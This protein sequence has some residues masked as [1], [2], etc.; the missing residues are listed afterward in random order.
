MHVSSSLYSLSNLQC[1][2]L[3]AQ[4]SSQNNTTSTSPDTKRQ[5]LDAENEQDLIL[6]EVAENDK[7][8]NSSRQSTPEVAIIEMEKQVQEPQPSEPQ[9]SEPQSSESQPSEPQPV[10]ISEHRSDERQPSQPQDPELGQQEEEVLS[11][12]AYL[13]VAYPFFSSITVPKIS[14]TSSFSM[15]LAK[16]VM[17]S[18]G[19]VKSCPD[20]DCGWL[21]SGLLSSG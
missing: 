17:W 5:K 18:L 14:S 8:E 1:F 6:V 16:L 12:K 19:V 10:S 7:E 9:S 13:T 20:N 11:W 2:I 15:F 4:S 21:F 3:N